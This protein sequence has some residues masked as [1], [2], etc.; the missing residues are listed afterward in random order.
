MLMIPAT[1]EA[2]FGRI[3]AQGQSKL[4][5]EILSQQTG[6]MAYA[7]NP[8]YTSSVD[9]RIKIWSQPQAKIWDPIW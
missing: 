2:E 8:S 3:M 7:C 9:R 5:S 6:V 4:V 1:W